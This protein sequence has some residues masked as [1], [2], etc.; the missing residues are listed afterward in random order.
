MDCAGGSPSRTTATERGRVNSY[1]TYVVSAEASVPS[2]AAAPPAAI[3]ATA[4][5][6]AASDTSLP[7]FSSPAGASDL[8]GQPPS[9]QSVPISPSSS[10]SNP[11]PR[12]CS[13]LPENSICVSASC[14][15]GS[16]P[17]FSPPSTCPQPRAPR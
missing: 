14:R 5:A 16:A 3:A 4:A 12:S 13:Q 15:R 7:S 11:I 2:I 17:H 1:C 8:A 10:M 9:I 6:A